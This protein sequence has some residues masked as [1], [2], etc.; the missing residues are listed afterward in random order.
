MIEVREITSDDLDAI[1]E[2][3]ASRDPAQHQRRLER[4]ER[5][6]GFVELIGWLDGRAAGWAALGYLHDA[7]IEEVVE[8][9]GYALV[10]D[11]HVEHE[12]RRRGVGRALMLALEE[13][14]R[15]LG[16]PGLILDTGTTEYFAPARG[17]Y[18]SLGYVERGGVYLGGWSDPDRPGVSFVDP[19]LQWVKTW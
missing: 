3:I 11:L 18:R 6:D 19:L 2:G 13:R 14:A 12:H 17:L 1:V 15:R 8:S 10:L 5:G 9:R 16:A 7:D 4:H